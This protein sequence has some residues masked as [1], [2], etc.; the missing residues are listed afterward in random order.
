MAE[1]CRQIDPVQPAV[2]PTETSA[3]VPP[4]A[5]ASVR[6]DDD[7]V[8]SVCQLTEEKAA[9]D[10]VPG[11]EDPVQPAFHPTETSALVPP[12][13]EASVG[14]NDDPV[15]PVC[16]LT[17]EKAAEDPVQGT[18]DLVQ[19]AVHPTDTSAL[20]PE[21]SPF[22]SNQQKRRG[23]PRWFLGKVSSAFDKHIF[24]QVQRRNLKRL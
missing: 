18:D 17:E 20:E 7:P 4:A 9:E 2:H 6:R 12:A 10:P 5:E 11:M 3:L 22:N 24:G 23:V 8:Q 16:H 21:L 14:R 1:H 13:A 19:P 15:Q